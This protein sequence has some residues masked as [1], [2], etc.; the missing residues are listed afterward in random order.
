MR[1]NCMIRVSGRTLRRLKALR[2][3]DRHTMNDVVRQLLNYY[4]NFF[5]MEW[6][7]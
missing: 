7:Q 4:D 1:H 6:E 3:G 2:R 5:R